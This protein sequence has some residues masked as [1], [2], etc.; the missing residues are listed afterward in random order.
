MPI[1][2]YK[3]GSFE[4]IDWLCDESWDLPTQLGELELWLENRRMSLEPGE[5]VADIGFSIRED[6]SGGGGVLSSK[7]MLIMG[8]IGMDVFFSE[9]LLSD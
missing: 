2:I 9:Y 6:A 1:N 4:R 8:E 3:T 5:Y 7:A